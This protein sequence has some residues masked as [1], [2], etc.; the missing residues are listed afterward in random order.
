M[1]LREVVKAVQGEAVQGD[2]RRGL[3]GAPPADGRR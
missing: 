2:R 3:S 1:A